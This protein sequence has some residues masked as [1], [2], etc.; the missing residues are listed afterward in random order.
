M[1]QFELLLIEDNANDAALT[2]RALNRHNLANRVVHVRDGQAALDFLLG[3]GAQTGHPPHLPRLVL[4]D[5]K[6][7]KVDGLSVLRRIRA[8]PTLANVPVVVLTSSREQHDVVACYRLGINSFLVK[9][10][11]FE[12]F[13]DVV[14]R[15]G[16]YWLL[17][18]QPPPENL[19]GEA[20]PVPA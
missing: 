5:L 20:V 9:P 11:E 4:L 8:E 19:G 1:P 13:S 6:L 15:L 2:L 17:L 14:A 18:N 12:A 16:F 7:P 10:V 3:K